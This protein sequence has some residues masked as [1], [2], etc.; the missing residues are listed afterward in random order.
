MESFQIASESHVAQL[1]DFVNA[2]YRG[3]SSK[4]GWTT[5][6]DFL[7]GQR[8]DAEM[9]L[10]SVKSTQHEILLILEDETIKACCEV[11][12]AVGCNEVR[13]EIGMICVTPV[14]QG[15]GW[16]RKMVS[17]AEKFCKEKWNISEYIMFV[18]TL[19]KPLIAWYEKLGY[20]DSGE[21][22]PFP[23]HDPKFGIPKILNIEF[24]VMKKPI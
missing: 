14:E 12:Q 11:K 3:E 19:R 18:I 9:L 23:S 22:K 16:G 20:K 24:Q 6:A 13:A 17:Y 7:D 15:R 10:E 21:R 2:A 8:I 1:V 4:A 5:E